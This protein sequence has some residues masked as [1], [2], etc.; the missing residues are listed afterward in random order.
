MAML[1]V[2]DLEVYYGMIQAIKGISFE[3]NQGEVIALIGANGAG[4]TTTLQTITGMLQ[5]KK[6]HILFEGQDITKVPGHKIV[7]MGMAH[8]P[9]GRRVFANLSVYENLKLGA[10]TR[11]DKNEIAESLEMVYESFPR[12]KER[13]NQSAGTL[14]G[15]EQQMLAMGRALMSKPRI[16]LMDEPSMGLSPIFVDEIFKIIQQVSAAGTT[17]LLV[18]QNAKKALAIADRAYVLETGK[19]FGRVGVTMEH[20]VITIARSYGSGGRTLG[21]LLAKELGVHCYDREL[22]R[23]ASEQSG[24]N[25]ALFG[26]VD[27]KVKS[28]PLFGI[29]KKIYKG[30]IF[31][32]ESDDFVSDDNLFNYQ[33]KIIKEVAAEESCVIIGRCADFILKDNPNVVR[34]FFYAPKEDCIARVKTQN[35]GTEKE[36]IRKIEKTDK[37]RSDYY[38]YHTGKDWNDSRNYDF[39]LNTASMSYEKLVAVV[40]AYIE[41][42]K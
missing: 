29:S 41:Q 32:P 42:Y 11:K 2:K 30:E 27:E 22:L 12:L 4:K 3:V 19:I 38:R 37:Y 35:G 7:T 39:C 10:Y 25:E 16:I 15:G 40:K 17:V 9:E 28:L 34:L 6:G 14:S 36:I 31:P 13:R 26:E 18:E 33:A 24:I 8:V 20:T 21:K 1:E 5:A 23:M